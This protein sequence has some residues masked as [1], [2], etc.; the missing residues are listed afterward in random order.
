MR[1]SVFFL[2][3]LGFAAPALAD[4]PERVVSVGGALT[5]IVYAL[6]A[7]ET[8]VAVDTTS[9]YPPAA[10]E[11]PDVGYMRQLAA[12]PILAL[13]PDLVLLVEDSGPPEVVAQL[14]AAGVRIERV[15][16]TPTLDG[17]REK[18]SR[19]AV[20][21]ERPERGETLLAE[22]EAQRQAVATRLA[23]LETH[24]R[25]LFLLSVGQGAPLA[26]GRETSA[27][28]IV[29]LAGGRNALGDFTGYKPLSPEAA[30]AAEPDVVLVTER[31]LGLLGGKQALLARPELAA[32][33][34]AAEGR[35]IAMDAL[36]LLGFGPRT[37][38]A[39][40]ELA[41]ALHPGL[42]PVR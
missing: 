3:L 20:A 33:P 30:V 14:E 7:G 12:E 19:V 41:E 37:P 36:L 28:G 38:Q 34:A 35:L 25:V 31:S 9:T 22:I 5:E 2:C 29:E 4:S 21:L 18:V 32:T 11:L 10:D 40:A 27:A 1:L 23:E 42:P 26:A 39:M 16:D 17:V 13:E 24:P 6:G 8:L 15:P